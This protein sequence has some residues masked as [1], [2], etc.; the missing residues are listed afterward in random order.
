MN[1]QQLIDR[2]SDEDPAATVRFNY[3]ESY[4]LQDDIRGVWML[5]GHEECATCGFPE[6]QHPIEDCEGFKVPRKSNA[7]VVY[8]V[9]AGQVYETPY[10]HRAAF[11]GAY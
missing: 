6:D 3:Q 11:E 9:S 2:L 1:V 4:P 8:I 10:G 5:D 7:G